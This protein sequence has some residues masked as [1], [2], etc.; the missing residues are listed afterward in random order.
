M[1]EK[2]NVIS[3]LQTLLEGPISIN[4]EN[5]R[6][7]QNEISTSE[8]VTLL[9]EDKNDSEDKIGEPSLILRD[10]SQIEE[11]KYDLDKSVEELKK[12]FPDLFK[13]LEEIEKEKSEL[14]N[15]QTELKDEMTQSLGMSELK[16]VSNSMFSVTYVAESQRT[17]FDRKGFE[18]KYPELCKQFITVSKVSAYTKWT[19]VK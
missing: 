3:D 6:I 15:K 19:R 9:D 7:N 8:K 5:T 14:E 10:Y 4:T 2:D 11:K 12:Q 1:N 18:K 13:R 17:N 16:N